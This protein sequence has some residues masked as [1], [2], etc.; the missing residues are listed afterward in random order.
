MRFGIIANLNRPGA[1][2]AIKRVITWCRGKGYSVI[3]SEDIKEAAD[4]GV[5]ISPQKELWKHADIIVSL[6]GDG[7]IL[8]TVRALG[9][10]SRPILGI[11]LGSLG[12]LTQVLPE[13]LEAALERL[14][15]NDFQIEERMLLKT[16]IL[17][18]GGLE[19]P[20]ALN[21]I[22]VD[23]GSVSR[24]INISLYADGEYI[25][26]YTADGLLVATPTGSTAYSLAVGGPILNPAMQAIIVSPISPFSLTSR[27][28]VFAPDIELEIR[29]RSG[30]GDVLLTIDGQVARSF[31][32]TGSLKIRRARHTAKFIKLAEN[33]FYNILRQKLHWGK[34]PVVD[35]EKSDFRENS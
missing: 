9:K 23:K 25:S 12:F 28:L 6:G 21:D 35:Y 17:N 8:A 1:A 32:P 31:S 16:E 22:V 13:Q 27:P 4:V 5:A 15:G 20:Y 3:I 29:V 34:L 11:N 33:S 30:H 2:D 7:T 14:A 26:S 18:G 19:S 24:V 10:N